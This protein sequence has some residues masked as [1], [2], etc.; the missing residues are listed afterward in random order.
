QWIGESIE[1]WHWLV[2]LAFALNKEFMYRYDKKTAHS[3]IK[4]IEKI[5]PPP[6]PKIKQTPF[7]QAMPEQYKVPDN[8]VLAYRNFYV[9]EK[10]D[11]CHWT[12]RRKP[13]W[14]SQ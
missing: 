3:S 5:G 10:K 12:K 2:K 13:R 14:F 6:L 8:P 9:G 1:N 4:I 11:F 7:A